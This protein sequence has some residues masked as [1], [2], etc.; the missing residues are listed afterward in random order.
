MNVV[1]TVKL[2]ELNIQKGPN[3]SIMK[4]KLTKAM[5]AVSV[6]LMA[7]AIASA[8]YSAQ[9]YNEVKSLNP[10]GYW[11]M[12]E[13][14][15]PAPGDTETNYGSIGLLGTGYYPDWEPIPTAPSFAHQS[16]PGP[17][18][19]D[20]TRCLSFLYSVNTGSGF[21]DAW[22]TNDLYIPRI[23]PLIT[24]NTNW[25]VECWIHNNNGVPQGGG[26]K[27]V[28]MWSE[29]GFDILNSAGTSSGAGNGV[30]LNW[31]GS[32]FSELY[33]QFNAGLTYGNNTMGPTNQWLYIVMI[34]DGQTNVNTY[35]NGAQLVQPSAGASKFLPDTWTPFAIGGGR[36][37]TRSF[38]G[39]CADFAIYTNALN[40]NDI[41]ARY[42]AATTNAATYYGEVTNDQPVVFYK[43]DSPAYNPPPLSAWPAVY[44][45]ATTNGVAVG[46]GVYTPGTVPG[47]LNGPFN[48]NG[49]PFGGVSNQVVMLSGISS[50]AD[51]GNAAVYNVTG[52]NANFSV[53]A[54]F[55]GNPCDGRFNS[56]VSKGTNSWQLAV[57]TNGA[58]V[59]NAGNAG[60]YGFNQGATGV[61]PGDMQTV[62]V[63][64]DGNWHEVVAVNQ[65]NRVSIY[66][67]G[68][69]D[70]NGTPAGITT[71]SII[72]GNQNDVLIGADPSY[73]NFP[74]GVG[75]Q[76]AGQI[77]E[78]A[79]FTNALTAVQVQTLYDASG[80]APFVAG[81]PLS[82]AIDAGIAY[83]N[84]ITAGGNTPL[85]Y[86]WYTNGVAIGG[87]T[88][89]SLILNPAV[90]SE[91]SH[92]TVVVTNSYGSV[93]SAVA[94]LT[95]YTAPTVFG[96]FPVTQN[97]QNNTNFFTVYAGAYPSYSISALG[98]SLAY[99]WHTNGV[100]DGT[101]SNYNYTWPNA[102]QIGT[103]TV[104]GV[105]SNYVNAVTT[106]VWSASVIAD[107]P[108]NGV[109]YAPYPQAVLALHPIG[110]WRLNESDNGSGDNG[111]IA[112]D[113]ASGN[114]GIYT[115]AVLAIPGYNPTTDPSD[116]C[117][118]AGTW[119][120]NTCDAYAIAGSLGCGIDF[121]TPITTNA[122][123]SVE[124]WVDFLK[125]N[126]NCGVVSKGWNNGGEE[127]SICSTNSGANPCIIIRTANG[128]A[129]AAGGKFTPQVNTWYHFCGVC[130]EA[131]GKLS[132]YVNGVLAGQST[133]PSR[134]GI[135]DDRDSEGMIIGAQP[136][137]PGEIGG[138]FNT[139]QADAQ[140]NDVAVF[141][142]A[143]NASQIANQYGQASFPPYIGQQPPALTY[144]PRGSSPTIT[145]SVSGSVPMTDIW[146]ET[147][148]MTGTTHPVA[149]NVI[150]SS[151]SPFVTLTVPNIITN[152]TW[153]LTVS[154][155]FFVTNTSAASI[156]VY[157]NPLVTAEFPITY[158]NIGNTKFMRLYPGASPNFSVSA[159]GLATSTVTNT[160]QWFANGAAATPVT[161][162]P[163]AINTTFTMTNA[164]SSFSAYLV[165]SNSFGASTSA[166][167]SATVV[168]NPQR[169]GGGSALYPLQVMALH[170][171]EYW[172][173]NEADDG[174]NDGNPGVVAYDYASGNNG[175]YTN[176]VLDNTTTNQYNPLEDPS[177]TS[178]EFG[179][180]NLP[181]SMVQA[182][183]TN[184][185]FTASS[186]TV[187]GLTVEC[188]A[189]WNA[190]SSLGLIA[191]GYITYGGSGGVN[192][193][194]M[195]S[196][197]A[198]GPPATMFPS[199][200]VHTAAGTYDHGDG[201]PVATNVWYHLVGVCDE[202]NNL[203]TLYVNGVSAGSFGM[204][205]R[206]GILS[207]S[208]YNILIGAASSSVNNQSIGLADAQDYGYVSDVAIFNYALSPSQVLN[209]YLLGG[210]VG[211]TFIPPVAT[212]ATGGANLTLTIPMMAQGTPT[213]GYTWT[214]LTTGAA[215]G[216]GTTNAS[217]I[218]NAG[219]SYPNVPLSWN[220]D[221]LEVT[222]SN[223]IG[224]I[225]TLVTV[226]ITN[227]VNLNPTNIV[228]T[229]TNNL[230]YLHWPLDHTGWT[231]QAQTNS[232]SV[233]M[234]TNWV[235]VSGSATTNE[236]AV[237]VNPANGCVFY[238]L[239]YP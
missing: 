69:L 16:A 226:T 167:W 215:I 235:N 24:L 28:L 86:Q 53:A 234:N 208:A 183:G 46:N 17:L 79:F 83:T 93:T 184:V 159:L 186:T 48:P 127:F 74:V 114:N 68:L 132:F 140:I 54:M 90:A 3:F 13:T 42:A 82:Q 229:Q 52:S 231:L 37:G 182:I 49:L 166:V 119:N 112:T 152:D 237:P 161:I 20:P 111:V 75:R 205:G 87:Q 62:G 220:G 190:L 150:T 29:F 149:T 238:R 97:T 106:A 73:T 141:N 185:D 1:Q 170:P 60:T 5:L 131:G 55:R 44:N 101:A 45:V 38:A 189:N 191:K 176:A 180:L 155:S 22:F 47:I 181:N 95:I 200:G 102:A 233:G 160:Y 187:Q 115:N 92:Y 11:P 138:L 85:S 222:V 43:M 51:V 64:N 142:Y 228:T 59:F 31:N 14:N 124:C 174:L 199:F 18:A 109:G 76:F 218:L 122:E 204:A 116:T 107:P 58:I 7:A 123:F 206:L 21:V 188:W 12:H 125:T 25:T 223:A 89:A 147:N 88:N 146:W 61:S 96:E 33:D 193:F 110:Y 50:F 94:S 207:D 192:E 232:V 175:I 195:D 156:V 227:T 10:V 117:F 219:L 81:Q 2:S 67:D 32:W 214:N 203:T 236:I 165:M 139:L 104:Y 135:L 19:N 239:V 153:F 154:N 201:E 210:E 130:D 56:I 145:A 211:P 72:P 98:Q 71:T 40:P 144:A 4:I 216:S 100:Q 143:L 57:G 118:Q 198:A 197:Y 172:R 120:F 34:C 39:W 77:C 35:Y 129:Y 66:V 148:T 136:A 202:A 36:G 157:S 103:F 126:Q 6:L 8:Q 84:S 80:V 137:D 171:V 179:G 212:T 221:Q 217:G 230:L 163:T 113:Y 26:Y 65:T 128:N 177:G 134:S 70:T 108:T 225:S 41:T 194:E 23:S 133:I 15:A 209:Q 158:T 105:V 173:L 169:A 27:G 151:L 91:A 196:S 63:Y 213:L 224:S 9:Y 162:S 164:Q 78:V 168:S 178:A 121:A 99:Y 30:S